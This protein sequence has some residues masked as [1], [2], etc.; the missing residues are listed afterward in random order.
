[1]RA[2]S[3]SPVPAVLM[4][5]CRATAHRKKR[6][7]ARLGRWDWQ[8]DIRLGRNYPREDERDDGLG[9]V[10]SAELWTGGHGEKKVWK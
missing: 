7:W 2:L 8:D 10:S 6:S 5:L 4:S 9:E 1:M 3:P